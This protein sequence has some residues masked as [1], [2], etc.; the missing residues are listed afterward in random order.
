MAENSEN[1]EARLCAY[2]EGDL[3][4]AG[5]AEIEKHL[6]SH[7]NH[8]RLLAELKATRDLLR[9]LPREPAPSDLAE[10]FNAHLERSALLDGAPS[11]SAVP[12]LQ[13]NFL[14][15]MM[16]TAAIVVL[17]LGLAAIVYF[18]LPQGKPGSP[19]ISMTPASAT[20]PSAGPRAGDF[21][22]K[23]AAADATAR[24]TA[25]AVAESRPVD[26]AKSAAP[27]VAEAKTGFLSKAGE[28][29]GETVAL[30]L[31][32]NARASN[33]AYLYV[34]S[35]DPKAVVREITT[36]LSSNGIRWEPALDQAAAPAPNQTQANRAE[37]EVQ[38][39]TYAYNELQNARQKQMRQQQQPLRRFPVGG[40]IGS[41]S[42]GY[43]A[44]QEAATKDD[45]DRNAQVAQA[46]P[47]R[48][49]AGTRSVA[50]AEASAKQQ[51]AAKDSADES[52]KSEAKQGQSLQQQARQL[53]PAAEGAGEVLA[54]NA[55]SMTPRQVEELG[56]ALNRSAH[57]VELIADAEELQVAN[58]SL[59]QERQTTLGHQRELQQQARVNE[60]PS[61]VLGQQPTQAP[62]P[63]APTSR[64]T[65][66]TAA[67]K[68]SAHE[69]A[70]R[71]VGK[72]APR[73]GE[74][75]SLKTGPA[76]PVTR[77]SQAG[78]SNAEYSVSPSPAANENSVAGGDER[79]DLSSAARDERIRPGA[80]LNVT[81]DE[82]A[83]PGVDNKNVAEVGAD[84]TV[85]LPKIP[86]IKVADLTP[87]QAQTAIEDA[88]I[89]AQV[90]DSATVTVEPV[91]ATVDAKPPTTRP[92]PA[93][94]P[95][96]ASSGSL[97]ADKVD[98]NP[99]TQT[100]PTSSQPAAD[101]RLNVVILVQ[102][103][104]APATTAPTTEPAKT[105]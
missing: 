38:P 40:Q 37:S 78:T 50:S 27:T 19:Q 86:P 70:K 51:V 79:T 84:G 100:A 17:G 69:S 16:A 55:Y 105:P 66:V 64:A 82:L 33:A 20:E 97:L 30:A 14:P 25:A 81:V 71:Y 29:T 1:I 65:E 26:A 93:A 80:K 83:A 98:A 56:R 42:G 104:L 9:Y 11:E 45:V 18:S 57:S 49:R 103:N 36:N 6:E 24:P 99:T 22:R 74:G 89:N 31:N 60:K 3:D 48:E 23:V 13:G 91:A 53:R 63:Q 92:S 47:Q 10:M 73:N 39:S 7:P 94:A 62:Q 101:Q 85:R 75:L 102:R 96:T 54:I 4:E 61:F 28:P 34:C 67:A 15:R 95:T 88:Y 44:T 87:S 76:G 72:M 41:A 2:V 35:P 43:G 90:L 58:A 77:P 12:R 52:A 68:P 46:L 5:L 59:Q 21:A 8:R 32:T